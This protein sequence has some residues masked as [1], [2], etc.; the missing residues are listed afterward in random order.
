MPG[1]GQV[2]ELA[3]WPDPLAIDLV[4]RELAFS[5]RGDQQDGH[6]DPPDDLL[7]RSRLALAGEELDRAHGHPRDH[8][9]YR[10]TRGEPGVAGSRG[11]GAVG[12]DRS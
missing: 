3:G 5:V 1:V 6:V 2:P 10:A 4:D 11:A 12:D 8:P 9:R 7:E